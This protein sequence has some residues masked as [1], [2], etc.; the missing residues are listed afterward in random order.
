[1]AW[2]EEAIQTLRS[3]IEFVERTNKVDMVFG[4]A[5]FVSAHQVRVDGETYEGEY[6]ILATGSSPF[7]PPIKGS[8]DRKR[9]LTSDEILCI[10]ELPSSL[11]IIG[12]GVIGVEF[13]SY[14]SMLGVKVCV[15]EMMDEILPMMDNEFARLMRRSMSGVDFYL[16][17]KVKE[18]TER[19]VVYT[20]AK[21][22]EQSLDASLVLLSIGRKANIGGLEPLHLELGPKGVV[23]DG[24]MRT[25][26]ENIYAI[27]DVNGKSQ[28]AHSAERMAIVAISNIFGNKDLEM[29]YDAIPWVVYGN[30]EASGCGLTE[31]EAKKQGREVVCASAF[32]RSNGR[33]LAEQGKKAS[34]LVKLV[35]DAK[36]L[37]ILGVHMIGPYSSEII[38][39][40]SQIIEAGMTVKDIKNTIFPH[41]SV[42]EVISACAWALDKRR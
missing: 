22:V 14:F 18:I 5:V 40:A 11:A 27:G 15:I 42:S 35:A 32:M 13:A 17:C 12:G 28:L 20:D 4:E 6:L 19:Q 9:V 2:K 23:V 39:G 31:T 38:W 41:P 25:S 30:P 16:G 36:T 7:L 29:R 37:S 10:D 21:G 24:R 8:E 33:F 3:S 1:M 34:G 26:V